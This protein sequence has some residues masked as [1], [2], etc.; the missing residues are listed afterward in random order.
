M[1]TIT[2][3]GSTLVLGT[4][5]RELNQ[6]TRE[7][8]SCRSELY[9]GAHSLSPYPFL[10]LSLHPR[11]SEYQSNVYCLTKRPL[12]E[13]RREQT[14]G[15]VYRRS[16]ISQKTKNSSLKTKTNKQKQKM[17]GQVFLQQ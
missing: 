5:Y 8:F 16:K 9:K 17:L 1:T 7:I 13:E 11:N 6:A 14:N 4:C 15:N 2:L 10:R 12:E 3:I